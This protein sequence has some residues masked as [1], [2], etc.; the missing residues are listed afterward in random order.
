[1]QSHE[2]RESSICT[3]GDY[4]PHKYYFLNKANRRTVFKVY[5]L[6]GHLGS[7]VAEASDS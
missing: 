2:K 3:K 7:S 5:H 1:M 4:I 6:L